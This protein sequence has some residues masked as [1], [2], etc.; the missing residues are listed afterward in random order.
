MVSYHLPLLKRRKR[1]LKVQ[2][3]NWSHQT[4]SRPKMESF[5]MSQEL[6]AVL[7]QCELGKGTVQELSH[8]CGWEVLCLDCGALLPGPDTQPAHSRRR[9]SSDWCPET[10]QMQRRGRE[11]G[12]LCRTICRW[13]AGQPAL[14]YFSFLF[15]T[16]TF[17]R[18]NV[19]WCNN[20]L[21][22]FQRC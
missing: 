5:L 12:Q 13:G 14:A 2:R 4:K 20:T 1:W 7:C 19:I 10:S 8:P 21:P 16:G 22:S 18:P 17:Q 6:L 9:E 11:P 15:K 3:W